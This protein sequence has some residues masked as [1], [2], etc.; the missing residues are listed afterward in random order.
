MSRAKTTNIVTIV[1]WRKI[2]I[3]KLYKGIIKKAVA[4][5]KYLRIGIENLNNTQLGRLHDIS[6]PLP[7]RPGSRTGRFLTAAGQDANTIGKQINLA[8]LIGTVIGMRFSNV[9]GSDQNIEFERIESPQANNTGVSTNE[10]RDE[11]FAPNRM[12]SET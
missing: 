3:G 11:V 10:F 1:D 2:K 4:N 6:L 12:D 8:D 9:D 7:V 5:N